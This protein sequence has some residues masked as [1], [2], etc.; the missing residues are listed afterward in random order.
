[1]NQHKVTFGVWLKMEWNEILKNERFEM[2]ME[3]IEFLKNDKKKLDRSRNEN[4]MKR[5]PNNWQAENEYGIK[6][7]P[8]NYQFK[9]DFCYF[10]PIWIFLN[11]FEIYFITL[12]F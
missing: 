2:K 1:M 12:P 8:K 10:F 4:R 6:L 11:F 5:S 9:F 3:W 7:F